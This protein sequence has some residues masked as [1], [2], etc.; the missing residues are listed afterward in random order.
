MDWT[1][2]A[3]TRLAESRTWGYRAAEPAATEPTALVA[4]ALAHSDASTTARACDWL[5]GVQSADGSLGIDAQRNSPCWPT[6]W[7][8]LAWQAAN[9]P[10][11]AAAQAIA[12]MLRVAGRPIEYDAKHGDS[13]GHDTLLCGWPWVES[14][15]SWVEPTAIN[16]LA[17]QSSGQAEH[18]RAREAVRMLLDRQLPAGGWNYGNTVV[19]GNTLRP[20]VQPTGMA[21]WAL[22]DEANVDVTPSIDFLRRTLSAETTSASLAYAL[23]GLAAHGATPAD[24]NAWLAAAARRTLAADASPYK[25]A[26]LLLAAQRVQS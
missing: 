23:M 11:P 15:H 20:H 1:E 26:L 12:W 18:T 7:A 4:L 19:L 21:L 24:A 17:M 6:G 16:L 5:L 9:T 10:Q 25:L 14:T 22:Q 2:Q 3:R 8:V 13:E